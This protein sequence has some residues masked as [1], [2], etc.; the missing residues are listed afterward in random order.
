[1]V[2]PRGLKP[3]FTEGEIVLCYEPDTTK[4]KVLYE[5]KVL[6]VMFNKDARGKSKYE[7]LIHFQVRLFKYFCLMTIGL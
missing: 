7:Y 3:K 1:M 6:Q 2:L 4:A 5:S